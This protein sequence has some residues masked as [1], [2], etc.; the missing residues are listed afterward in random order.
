M[1][2]MH[3]LY[4]LTITLLPSGRDTPPTVV[5]QAVRR[6]NDL[7]GTLRRRISRAIAVATWLRDNTCS[8]S[9][10]L[11]HVDLQPLRTDHAGFS[12][13]CCVHA[14]TAVSAERIISFYH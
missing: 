11:M 13:W 6:N 1:G 12:L 3:T 14:H 7:T 4:R 5:S 10:R 8:N 9:V 2:T